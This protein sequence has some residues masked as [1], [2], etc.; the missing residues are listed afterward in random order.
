MTSSR[1]ISALSAVLLAACAGGKDS[2][3]ITK[4]VT[5]E[6]AT[7]AQR[8][9]QKALQEKKDSNFLEATRYFEWV[10]NNFPYSQYA[11]LSELSLADMAYERDD[12]A[13]AAAAYQDF[14]KSHPSHPKADYA[15]FRIGL[16]HYQ[17]KPSEWFLLPP[18]REKDQ[19]PIKSALD[20]FQ[21]FTL[22]YPKSEFVPKAR[23]L[24]AECRERLA[25][26]ERYVADFY[27]KRSAWKGAAGRLMG[28]ADTYGDLEGGRTRSDSLW[29]AAIAYR[30]APDLAN[31]KIA[32]QRLIQEAPDSP[33]RREAEKM[34]KE[35]PASPPAAPPQKPPPAQEAKPPAP[36]TAPMPPPADQP[37]RPTPPGQPDK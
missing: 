17:D 24:I 19:G 18:A 37:P 7:N 8:G 35:L 27:W 33:H 23:D 9:Y 21:R 6:A 3:D 12:Y 36:S 32:L 34:L 11:A 5:G 1:T 15:S 2:I 22:A 26:H 16:A 20:A 25:A 4:P 13:A 14:V 30:N 28:L 29:G 10:R 31:E